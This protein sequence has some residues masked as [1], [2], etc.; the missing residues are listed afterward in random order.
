M[1]DYV[2]FNKFTTKEE[3]L[4]Q[5]EEVCTRQDVLLVCG[6]VRNKT[7]YHV[8]MGG[9]KD[10]LLY[11]LSRIPLGILKG[12]VMNVL[13]IEEKPLNEELDDDSSEYEDEED[14]DEDQESDDD[15]DSGDEEDA[16]DESDDSEEEDNEDPDPKQKPKK[17]KSKITYAKG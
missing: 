2:R 14:S 9:T 10:Q 7:T 1:A 16:D 8:P 17:R 3:L 4:E 12:A 5:L 11:S 6:W 15:D 13:P